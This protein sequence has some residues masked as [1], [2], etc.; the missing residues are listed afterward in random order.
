M[1]DTFP[2]LLQDLLHDSTIR[3][4]LGGILEI[5]FQ[6]IQGTLDLSSVGLLVTTTNTMSI[7]STENDIFSTFYTKFNGTIVLEMNKA[8]A[9]TSFFFEK[10]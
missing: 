3:K 4:I 6:K 8:L 7:L 10:K 1:K 2:E 9:D 5:I